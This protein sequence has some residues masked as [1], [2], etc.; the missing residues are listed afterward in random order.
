VYHHAKSLSP[1]PLYAREGRP[2]ERGRGEELDVR[3]HE[4]VR[5]EPPCSSA[6]R[7]ASSLDIFSAPGE[8]E[9]VPDENGRLEMVLDFGTE[10]EGRLELAC[11]VP[12]LCNVY[13]TFGESAP[14]AEAWGV[15][16]QQPVPTEH[17]HLPAGG[18]HERTFDARGFRFVRLHVFDLAGAVTFHDICVHAWMAFRLR[19]GDMRCSDDRFQRVWQT[20][21]YTARLCT[22][23]D[24][25]WDGVKRDRHGWYGDAR[26]TQETTDLVYMDPIP[27]AKMLLRMPTDE[28][29][30][31]IPG[32]SFDGVAMLKQL[33]LTYGTDQPSVEAAYARAQKMM[34]WVRQSQVTER[35]LV[36]RT[37]GTDL[38]FGIG[39]LDW[40]PMPVGGRLEELSWLQFKYLEALGNMALIA[41]WL[42]READ[43]KR[44]RRQVDQLTPMLLDRFWRA[45]RGFAHTLN[46]ADR[47]WKKYSDGMEGHYQR[48]YVDGMQLGE[49]GPSRHSMALAA[50]AGLCQVEDRRKAV[51][52]VLDDP[53]VA[54]VI[55]PYFAYYEQMARAMCGDRPGALRNMRDYVGE[56]I[57]RHDS[58]CCWESY[59]PEVE[60]FRRWGLHEFPK[61]LCHGWSS[62]IVGLSARHL[63][64]LEPKSPGY[65]AVSIA[66]PVDLPWSFEASIPTPDGDIHVVRDGGSEPIRYRLPETVRHIGRTPEGVRLEGGAT[67]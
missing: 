38:F 57:E 67:E 41:G 54:P 61:S 21:V 34:G 64:G 52:R 48:T 45:E 11:T 63:L 20:S 56:Q 36:K 65:R 13:V 25:Y 16:G 1:D 39:F 49:S 27:A 4:L 37:E 22:R 33:I 55:T 53:D 6:E 3:P 32:Y 28:W 15:P 35:G 60:D 31:G 18:R 7:W 26:I 44:Y 66:P 23:E 5:L 47:R 40:S 43:A 2:T 59:E 10:V 50:W 14:E 46:L 19:R 62:G 51:L 17:W 9:L 29:A 12:D 42:G 58:A 8:V 30:N 24:C